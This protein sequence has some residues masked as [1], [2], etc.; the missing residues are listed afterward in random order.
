MVAGRE[1]ENRELMEAL[2]ELL[3]A[4]R[5]HDKYGIPESRALLDAKIAKARPLVDALPDPAVSASIPL[6]AP[7]E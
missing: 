1:L 2:G 5:H 7:E 3:L 6:T 4:I